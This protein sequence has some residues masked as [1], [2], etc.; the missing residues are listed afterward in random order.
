M[1]EVQR[2]PDRIVLHW[3]QLDRITYDQWIRLELDSDERNA[4]VLDYQ[5]MDAPATVDPR[6][7]K[8]ITPFKPLGTGWYFKG[9]EGLPDGR[10]VKT[11]DTPSRNLEVGDVWVGADEVIWKDADQEASAPKS[12]VIIT[13]DGSN[14]VTEV[15]RKR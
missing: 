13:R 2:L 4:K 8:Q 1:R 15:R 9:A 3:I 12:E 6:D 7:E 10:E 11:F 5:I 14:R